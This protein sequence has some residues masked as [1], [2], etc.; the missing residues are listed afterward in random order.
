MKT[1]TLTVKEEALDK[2][3]ALLSQLSADEVVVHC[4]VS[5]NNKVTKINLANFTI[6]AF[7][8]IDDP[9]ELQRQMRDEWSWLRLIY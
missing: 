9:V 5:D 8:E 3:M 4:P 2:V 6:S 7:D 1:V